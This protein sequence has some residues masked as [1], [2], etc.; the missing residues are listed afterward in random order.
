MFALFAAAAPAVLVPCAAL[1]QT[2]TAAANSSQVAEVV[3]TAQK[4]SENLQAVPQQV[5]VVGT[6][7]LQD[8]HITQLADIGAYVPGLQV[9]SGGT[10]G[11]TTLSLRGIAPIGPSATVGTYIDDTPVGS[12]SVQ[13]A[14]AYYSLDLMPYDVQRIEVLQGP[15]GTLYG[16]NS[17]GGLIK[18]VLTSPDLNTF[19]GNAGVDVFGISHA[20]DAG[21]GG[22][23]SVTGPIIPGTLGFLASYSSESTPGYINNIQTGQKGQ[24]DYW[25]QS[26]RLALLWQPTNDISLKLGAVLQRIDAA[27]DATVALDP[28][29]LKPIGGELTDNN[30]LAE[31]SRSSL[32]H[33]SL[34][35]S[36]DLHWA[37]L[38]SATSYSITSDY[39]GQDLTRSYGPLFPLVGAPAGT[40]P[41]SLDY[42]T[43]KVT[44]ELRLSSAP[45]DRIE[46]LVGGFYTHEDTKNSQNAD[47]LTFGGA[48][49]PG[50]DPLLVAELP[51]TYQ[52]LAAFG[53]V[54]F[55]LTKKLDV[56]GGLRYAY[57]NQTFDATATGFLTGAASLSGTSHEGVLTYNFNPK[58]QFTKDIQA[59]LRIASGYQAG[60]PNIPYPGVPA[61]VKSDTLTNYELG[62][63]S[64]FWDRRALLDVAVFY[65]DWQNI[66][67]QGFQTGTGFTYLDNGGSAK[68][69]GVSVDGSLQPIAG[70]TLS[71]NVTYTDA[72][73][74]QAVPEIGGLSG[75]RLPY[76]PLWSGSMQANYSWALTSDVAAHVGAGVRLV[77]D[78]YSEVSSSP[79]AYRLGAYGALDLNAD[80]TYKQYTA[81][82]F[83]KNVTD[84]RAYDY[85]AE[86][87]NALT[88]TVAQLESTLI[89]PRTFGVALDA[90]F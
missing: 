88:G 62:L 75:D 86:I 4:R 65:I 79:S 3:V 73:L 37:K 49:I 21:G 89:Q 12:T 74:T 42:I 5:N 72:A 15:Q 7:E 46:W 9:N 10:P 26:G 25:Q 64:E 45:G 24:N 30:Y 76:I 57:N 28:T 82:L 61:I 27:D 63:K 39:T 16:A 35:A 41:F 81:R 69:E 77:G 43:K 44:Q 29:T 66:Q 22:R 33:Y 23:L 78:R 11:Q 85:D 53:D 48:P 52:E 1:A 50:L 2:N 18:Y 67:V 38:I 32:Q 71:G 54:T 34:E 8:L 60:G 20:G 87:T 19:H 40:A 90:K 80:V 68:S 36:W 56:S 6:A 59:Y 58:Y 47:A 13:A 84:T 51:D 83:L 70:L 55:H 31:P 14:G 17:I